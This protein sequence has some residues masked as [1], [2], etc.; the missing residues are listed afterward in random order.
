[1]ALW[2]DLLACLFFATIVFLKKKP[3][4][5]L[6]ALF[7]VPFGIVGAIRLAKPGSPWARW[8]YDPEKGNER[9]RERRERKLARSSFRFTEGRSGRFERWFSD[10]LGGTPGLTQPVTSEHLAHE[11]QPRPPIGSTTTNQ[12]G[13]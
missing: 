11:R 5:G 9:T 4:V 8:F 10:L 6:L 1:V 12:I 7:L 2:I 13:H 3:F